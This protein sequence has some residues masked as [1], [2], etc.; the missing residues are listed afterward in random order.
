MSERRAKA[1]RINLRLDLIRQFSD[2]VDSEPPMWKFRK[3]R[4]WKNSKPKW[5]YSLMHRL[6]AGRVQGHE[7]ADKGKA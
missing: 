2:W 1:R 7:R 4:K 6:L 3:W 5:D